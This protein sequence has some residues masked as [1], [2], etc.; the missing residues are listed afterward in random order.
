[1]AGNVVQLCFNLKGEY[2][3]WLGLSR[4]SSHYRWLGFVSQVGDFRV[5]QFTKPIGYSLTQRII[6]FYGY[7]RLVRE[8]IGSPG[9]IGASEFTHVLRYRPLAT[10]RSS[11]LALCYHRS[12]F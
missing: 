1:M 7:S 9:T 2:S 5:S 12:R 8:S 10:D 6:R 4:I 3:H 11:T